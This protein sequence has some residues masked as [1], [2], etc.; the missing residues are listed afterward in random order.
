M[1]SSS[2]TKATALSTP[3]KKEGGTVFSLLWSQNT[4]NTSI[5]DHFLSKNHS[6]MTVLKK[7][8]LWIWEPKMRP[9]SN[10]LRLP[11]PDPLPPGRLEASKSPSNWPN[12]GQETTLGGVHCLSN[13]NYVRRIFEY[14][15][16]PTILLKWIY[17]LVMT[18]SSPWKDP[19]FLSSVNHLFRLGPSIFHGKL[20]NSQRV[21][22][23]YGEIGDGLWYWFTNC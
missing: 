5:F 23:I 1:D 9:S 2:K 4:V 12:P 20:L 10:V 13:S 22:S 8:D 11:S 16:S 3:K 6:P 19:P 15:N 21:I 14:C 7:N 18:D 17:P